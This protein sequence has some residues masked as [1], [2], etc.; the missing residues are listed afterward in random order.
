L[1]G[2]NEGA[3]VNV[4]FRRATP[5]DTEAILALWHAAG[6][7][8]SAGGDA[9]AVRGMTVNPAAAFVLAV[10]DGQ[11]VGSLIGTFD[12]WRGNM[13]R[14]AVRPDLRRRGIGRGLVREVEAA[15]AAWG[16]RRVTA[17]VEID[18]PWAAAFWTAVGYP[19]DDRVVRH[20][21]APG[22]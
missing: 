6:A 20:V 3:A 9:A 1:Y 5:G 16:V 12:G 21:G 2:S 15:F 10:L 7:S 8:I 13:Y 19:R 22:T 14:L 17:L 4:T 11:V 18:R